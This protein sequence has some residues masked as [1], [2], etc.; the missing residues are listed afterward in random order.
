VG[1]LLD[2]VDGLLDGLGVEAVGVS[3]ARLEHLEGAVQRL[4]ASRGGGV[5]A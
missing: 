4:D 1:G 5:P 2:G 3:L